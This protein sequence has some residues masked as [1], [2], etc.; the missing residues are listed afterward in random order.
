MHERRHHLV[1]LTPGMRK[2]ILRLVL[3]AVVALVF[4]LAACRGEPE[5]EPPQ[6]YRGTYTFDISSVVGGQT[7]SVTLTV[8]DGRRYS[9]IHYGVTPTARINFCS[10]SGNVYNFKTMTVVFEP[11]IISAGNC[12]TLRI[13]RGD[14]RA[15][16]RTHGDTTWFDRVS[17][18]SSFSF[19]LLK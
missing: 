6:T 14:F 13:P 8:T 2:Q 4:V 3:G 7:D 17:G 5:T 1:S 16:S 19:R 10:S 18:D 15:D 11:T 12:D 9:L